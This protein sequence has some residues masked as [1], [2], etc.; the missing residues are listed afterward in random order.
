MHSVH[1]CA[2]A[3]AAPRAACLQHVLTGC[4]VCLRRKRRRRTDRP[5]CCSST[6]D[7]QARSQIFAGAPTRRLSVWVWV[8][9]RVC[10]SI[11]QSFDGSIIVVGCPA[12]D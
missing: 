7:T 4:C 2:R 8:H 6:G 12:F 5:S 11:D 9:G 1:V 10:G 3:R